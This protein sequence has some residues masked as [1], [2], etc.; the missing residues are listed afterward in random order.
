M[1]QLNSTCAFYKALSLL[2]K[3]NKAS[4]KWVTE[5]M[6]HEEPD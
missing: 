6:Q 3:C 1:L 4:G 2:S 5:M